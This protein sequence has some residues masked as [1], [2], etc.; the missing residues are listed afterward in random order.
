[1]N[2]DNKDEWNLA[3]HLSR[4]AYDLMDINTYKKDDDTKDYS[5]AALI[6]SVVSVTLFI[7]LIFILIVL[8]TLA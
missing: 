2:T 5:V 7:A 6:C 3:S 8:N 1:M 4:G